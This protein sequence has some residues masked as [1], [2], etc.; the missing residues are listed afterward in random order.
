MNKKTERY[1]P[2]VLMQ[3]ILVLAG[4]TPVIVHS[5]TIKPSDYWK[6]QIAF[7]V[8]PFNRFPS[9]GATWVKFTILLEPYNPNLVYFQNSKKYK[10]HYDFATKQLDPFVGMTAQQ[11]YAAISVE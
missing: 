2:A 5:Q 7:P 9:G 3:A 1:H 11:F 6:N 4:L 10:L 8:D